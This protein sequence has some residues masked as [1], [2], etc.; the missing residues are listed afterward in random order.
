MDIIHDEFRDEQKAIEQ[1]ISQILD[2]VQSKNFER[3]AKYHLHSPKFTKFNDIEPLERQDIDAC[4]RTEQDELEAVDH[5]DG[6]AHEL[7]I[8]VFGPVAIVTGILEFSVEMNGERSASRI[9]T[10]VV[11]VNDGG[12]WKIAHE[13]LSTFAPSP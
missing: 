2:A 11:F 1:R 4:N 6:A 10:T 8:D 7:K 9:R 12:D 13:H 5:V 3:L